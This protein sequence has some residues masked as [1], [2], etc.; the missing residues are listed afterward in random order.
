MKNISFAL[1]FIILIVSNAKGQNQLDLWAGHGEY[2]QPH[3]WIGEMSTR[4]AK[5]KVLN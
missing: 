2:G 3:P 1:L 4:K 5:V